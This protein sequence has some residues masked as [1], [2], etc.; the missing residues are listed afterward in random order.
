MKTRH[1]GIV[2]M[3]LFLTALTGAHAASLAPPL[4]DGDCGEYP[5]LGVKPLALAPEVDLFVYQDQHYV[6]L[7]YTYAD[8]SY[9]T[10]DLRLETPALSAPLNLHVS[11]QI[12]E[13]PAEEPEAA[14]EGPQSDRWWNAEGWIANPV[15]PNGLD[16][17]GE[18]VRPRYKND[19]AREL[20][21]SRERFGQGKWRFSLKIG[22]LRGA[23]GKFHEVNF[24]ADGSL[25]TLVVGSPETT[26]S[27]GKVRPGKSR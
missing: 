4:V 8:N 16:E 14:P 22:L 2:W 17:S 27:E 10:V 5:G 19:P 26:A 6:W 24:P 21:L 25:H 20:Q 13:W 3:A 11:A 12:G 9:G 15:W 23:D 7:C 18:T 1:V